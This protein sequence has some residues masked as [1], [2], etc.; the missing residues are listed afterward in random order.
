MICSDL[1]D[2]LLNS[3]RKL[4]GRIKDSI[5]RYVEFGG[6]FVIATGRMTFAALPIARELELHGEILTFQ[7]A[8]VAD[9]D[10]GKVIDNTLIPNDDAIKICKFIETTDY[11]FHTYIEDYFV[12]EK[13]T[14]YTKM[15]ASF[16]NCHYEICRQKL[17]EYLKRTGY[18]PPKI[19]IFAEP[20]EVEALIIKVREKFGD[21]YLVNTSKPWLVEIVSK[22]IN[23]AMAIKKL[24]LK[25]NIK[26]EEIICIGDSANDAPMLEF[27]GLGAA[28]SNCTEDAKKAAD[29]IVPS[30]DEDGVAFVIDTYGFINS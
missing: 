2:T 17:S 15:Y 5:R 23:K 13:E 12:A 18:M 8:I 21:K 22:D 24:A 7:G 29:I 6:K 9:I 30:C 26:Q 14:K 25:Y 20:E 19:V 28:V 27:A 10:S 16:C 4:T 11:Y 1:D 3:E